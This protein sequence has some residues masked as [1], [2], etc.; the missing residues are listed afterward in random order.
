MYIINTTFFFFKVGYSIW[1]EWHEQMH[2]KER[3][4]D[5]IWELWVL[6]VFIVKEVIYLGSEAEKVET[7]SRFTSKTS[8][9]MKH[10]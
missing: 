10:K 5:L 9:A 4:W 1:I 7:V 2:E 3:V 6:T 8:L